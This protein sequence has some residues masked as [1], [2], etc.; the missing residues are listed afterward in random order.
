MAGPRAAARRATRPVERSRPPSAPRRAAARPRPSRR[1]AA[2]RSCAPPGRC[3]A[4]RTSASSRPA[5][6]A[7][8]RDRDRD[9]GPCRRAARP[10]SRSSIGSSGRDALV[11]VEDEPRRP[12]TA[13]RRGARRA[14]ESSSRRQVGD[15][16]GVAHVAE[17]D[18]PG[19]P[20]GVV[21]RARCRSS[22]RCGRPGRGASARPGTTTASKR[23]STR[24]T[25]SR[26]PG[27]AD[28][29]RK[30][31]RPGRRAGRPRASC[32]A[33]AGW[34]KPR[35]ATAEARGRLAPAAERGVRRAR[36][37]RSAAA[38]QDVV[39]PDLVDRRRRLDGS[40]GARSARRLAG[41][42]PRHEPRHGQRQAGVD[43]AGVEHGER[44]HVEGRRV[45]GR[46][47][48]LHHRERRVGRVEQQERLV[49]LAAEVARV[50]APRR[51]TSAE[52]YR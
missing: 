25:R 24:S 42:A 39:H 47:R 16:R 19:D 48:D 12:G 9:R 28:G 41:R 33:R 13:R 27:V 44:L 15:E 21:D 4:R 18:D 1:P 11:A 46:V 49:A 34:R 14:S 5:L 36:A 30:L 26:W 35:R 51:R 38:G 6:G 17:V 43:P 40:R 52:R 23:S 31:A 37:G 8:R 10:G 22:G 20:P 2:S 45:L 50:A 7:P 3:S 32:A 29:A